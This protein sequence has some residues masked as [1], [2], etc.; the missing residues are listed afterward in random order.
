MEDQ[1]FQIQRML[2]DELDNTKKEVIPMQ[3]KTF[4]KF[5]SYILVKNN[6]RK[7][8]EELKIKKLF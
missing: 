2:A 5:R 3:M 1:A 4:E 6:K 8:K 7:K